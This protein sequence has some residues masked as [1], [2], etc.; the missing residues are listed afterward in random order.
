MYGFIFHP[1]TTPKDTKAAI[2]LAS[3]HIDNYIRRELSHVEDS[4]DAMRGILDRFLSW[5]PAIHHLCGLPI[6]PTPRHGN[7]S[8]GLHLGW[9]VTIG[10]FGPKSSVR[11]RIPHMF[12]SWT[13]ASWQVIEGSGNKWRGDN[14]MMHDDFQLY[15][16][17]LLKCLPDFDIF[18]G[19]TTEVE[20]KNHD[21]Y[22][23]EAESD[24]ILSEYE[25]GREVQYLH[26]KGWACEVNTVVENSSLKFS[27]R[28]FMT[29]GIA[30]L[31]S[32]ESDQEDQA[33]SITALALIAL[34][35]PYTAK[36]HFLM[37]ILLLRKLDNEDIYERVG[38]TYAYSKR[39]CKEIDIRNTATLNVGGHD[40]VKMSLT[41]V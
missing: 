32:R 20:F 22:S 26:V 34:K 36:P 17:P 13:W 35:D 11:R 38:C 25:A 28:G 7:A 9:Y 4:I 37:P 29:H 8:L 14:T 27:G 33:I 15:T 19:I 5:T 1:T 40:M 3:K 39:E 12:P 21:R 41:L 10:A 16:E 6:V 2:E 23:W 30:T 24:L 18:Y 31:L